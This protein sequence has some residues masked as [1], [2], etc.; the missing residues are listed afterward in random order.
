LSFLG[1]WHL[2]YIYTYINII[3]HLALHIANKIN[4]ALRV[5]I[6][7]IDFFTPIAPSSDV[8]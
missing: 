5:T 1:R 4:K 8:V 2:I 6:I 3:C 7:Q